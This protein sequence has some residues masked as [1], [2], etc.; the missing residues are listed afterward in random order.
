M[1]M[2]LSL[3]ALGFLSLL[4]LGKHTPPYVCLIFSFAAIGIG[5]TFTMPAATIAVIQSALTNSAGI[6]SGFLM[7]AD[8]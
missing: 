6:A 8:N 2:G 7:P 1:I 5:L 3:G 4:I